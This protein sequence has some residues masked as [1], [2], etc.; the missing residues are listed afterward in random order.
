[1]MVLLLALLPQPPP[2]AFWVPT[3]PD[4]RLLLAAVTLIIFNQFCKD[5]VMNPTGLDP[6]PNLTDRPTGLRSQRVFDQFSNVVLRLAVLSVNNDWS[7][8]FTPGYKFI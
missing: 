8:N 1:M 5:L 6:M 3:F 4:H 2:R 7:Y